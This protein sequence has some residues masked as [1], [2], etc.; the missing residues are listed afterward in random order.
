MQDQNTVITFCKYPVEGKVK[1]RIAKTIGNEFA[2]KIYKIFA[3]HTFR[4]LLKTNTIV[5]YLFFT[6]K[7][8]REKIQKWTG[9]KFLLE[10]QEGN[11]LGDRMYNACKKVI[12]K[13]SKKTVIIGTD[14]PDI[15]SEIIRKA[16]KAL[17]NSDVV[18]GPS[19]DGGYY[20][21][22]MKKLH[23]ALFSGIEW[24][25]ESVLSLTVEKLNILNLSYSMLPELI[26]V[27]TE[28]DLKVWLDK[29]S[30]KEN[31]ILESIIRSVLLDHIETK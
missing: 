22:G 31:N 7:N 2:V 27:D 4:E 26:D 10:L 18:I 28:D 6:E 14:I 13:G 17:D 25:S 12:D 21:L 30:A 23:R 3:E 1:T 16:V 11:D 9:S 20:L 29:D 15:S 8:D 5:P 24:S 19:N